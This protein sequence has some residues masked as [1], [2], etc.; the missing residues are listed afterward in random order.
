MWLYIQL[1]YGPNSFRFSKL[2]FMFE[3]IIVLS[4][5]GIGDSIIK[6]NQEEGHMHED[7]ITLK[8]DQYVVFP[9]FKVISCLTEYHR[10]WNMCL[11]FSVGE[12]K[13]Y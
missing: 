12:K 7:L 13:Q 11:F 8:Q 10:E 2:I 5:I 9:A 4:H 6:V 1:Y 3:V